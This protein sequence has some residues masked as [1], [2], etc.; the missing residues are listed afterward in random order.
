VVCVL[1]ALA[2]SLSGCTTPD[3]IFDPETPLPTHEEVLAGQREAVRG[4][5]RLWARAVVQVDGADAAGNELKEQAEGVLQVIPPD[6]LALSLGKLGDTL[7][8]LG[9]NEERYWWFDLLDSDRRIAVIG[10][11]ELVTPE[12]AATLGVPVHPLDLVELLAITPLSEGSEVLGWDTSGRVI[13]EHPTRW[14]SRRIWLD[15]IDWKAWRVELLDEAGEQ[16]ASAELSDHARASVAGDAL[17]SPWVAGRLEVRAAGF[18]GEVR[19]SLYD[20]QNRRIRDIAFD[21][22]R[23]A[24]D[25]YKINAV[26]DLDAV[27]PETDEEAQP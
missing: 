11:H 9:S 15:P 1:L 6:R 20:Q 3:P 13:V 19:V 8:Y 5:E 12:K 21:L 22:G 14:G 24:N 4:L 26:H 23:L 7:L 18:D 16:L 27:V 10:R 17:T 2:W 25:V